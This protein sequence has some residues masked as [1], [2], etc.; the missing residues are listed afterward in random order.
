[1]V[2]TDSAGEIADAL[3]YGDAGAFNSGEGTPAVDV[4][5][6]NSLSRDSAH[7]D[8]DDNAADF[9]EGAPSPGAP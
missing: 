6:G 8:S 7:T 9:L 4:A 2:L 5:G 3:Q 1:M